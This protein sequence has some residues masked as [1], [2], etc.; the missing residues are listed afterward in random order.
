MIWFTA[1]EDG[2]ASITVGRP[3]VPNFETQLRISEAVYYE[4]PDE[5]IIEVR[6]MGYEHELVDG[7]GIMLTQ[8][9]PG[10]G[11]MAGFSDQDPENSAFSDGEI[12][13]I[14]G[15]VSRVQERLNELGGLS[16]EQVEILTRKLDDIAEASTRMGRKDWKAL[17]V[18]SLTSVIV[19]SAI[20]TEQAK[21]FFE[22]VSS[23]LSWLYETGI[24]LIQ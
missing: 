5:G 14:R 19:N 16:S 12:E 7:A 17:A 23:A 9:G 22:I 21:Q 18:G 6:L 3:G 24:Q 10:K 15:S 1:L 13:R 4:T 8:I 11:M 20:E 2:V